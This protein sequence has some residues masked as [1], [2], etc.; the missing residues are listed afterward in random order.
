MDDTLKIDAN[1]EELYENDLVA[2][3]AF[4]NFGIRYM[5]PWQRL[6]V[7][8]I[9]DAYE[10]HKQKIDTDNFCKGRQI[11]LLPTG[12][13]KSLCFQ[14]PALLLDGPSLIIYPLLALMT[15]Q[16]RRM[17]EGS[18]RS[19]LFRGGQS[20]KERQ[21]NFEKIK[22]GAQIIL[23]NP[24]VLQSDELL[25]QLSQVGIKHIAIDEAHCV[26]E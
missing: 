7:S 26:S 18:L 3:T 12:A 8:N 22:N 16:Q 15:D 6:V 25:E 20:D 13:G 24:E 21:D 4:K 2:R 23:A 1:E 14:V 17:E 5:F 9:L 11:V 10:Y 19:V